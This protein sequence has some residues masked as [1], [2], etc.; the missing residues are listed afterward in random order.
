MRASIP[1]SQ[2]ENRQVT[3]ALQWI[4]WIP[5]SLVVSLVT[6]RG[7]WE[8]RHGHS[9]ERRNGRGGGHHFFWGV[10]SFCIPR[11]L[12]RSSVTKSFNMKKKEAQNDKMTMDADTRE[13]TST[14]DVG[15]L[16]YMTACRR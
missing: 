11:I 12:S 3:V 1:E 10:L 4:V 5:D 16:G 15:R 14:G 8:I 9:A 2:N 6:P 13:D 7:F